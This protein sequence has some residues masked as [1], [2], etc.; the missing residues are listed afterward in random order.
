LATPNKPLV[1]VASICIAISWVQ[2][3]LSMLA[4]VVVTVCVAVGLLPTQIVI[5]QSG[6]TFLVSFFG[7]FMICGAVWIALAFSLSCPHC[8][9]KF[10]KNPKGL[11]PTKF[12]YHANCSSKY[13]LNG[14]AVQIIN[15]LTTG[16]IRCINCGDEIFAKP[17]QS[18]F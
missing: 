6:R 15:F 16:R 1:A 5:G 7:L 14:W 4:F 13:R 8:G 12:Q 2:V 3:L 11:G 18:P 17:S 9:F 10:L